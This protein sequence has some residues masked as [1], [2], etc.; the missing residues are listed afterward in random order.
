MG[1]GE[2]LEICL[3]KFCTEPVIIF[4]STT[5]NNKRSDESVIARKWYE[6]KKN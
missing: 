6:V 3:E 2:V 4:L 5:A 1:F